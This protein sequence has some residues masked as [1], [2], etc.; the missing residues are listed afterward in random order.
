[1][2]RTMSIAR[3]VAGLVLATGV[4]AGSAACSSSDADEPDAAGAAALSITDP[5][6]KAAD[7]GM[8]G[9]FGTIVN[10]SDHDVRIV[11]ASAELAKAEL[12]E[13]VT[14][15]DGQMVMRPKADGIVV[16]A[17]GEHEL[18]PGGDHVML[19]D[20]TGP[21][22]PGDDVAVT[23]TADDGSTFTFTASART[24]AGANEKYEPTP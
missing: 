15:G 17:H 20:L 14:G 4:V 10:E 6:I 7:T 22:E 8:T 11:S 2:K 18:A 19:M 21:I 3:A 12:H 5:W 16:P 23:L 9:A 1:M 13:S 24:Y